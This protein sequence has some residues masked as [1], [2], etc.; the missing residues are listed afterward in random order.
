[1]R[2]ILA[3]LCLCVSIGQAG[4]TV[5][6]YNISAHVDMGSIVEVPIPEYDMRM[7]NQAPRPVNQYLI[8]TAA[9]SYFGQTLAAYLGPPEPISSQT[10]IP[11]AVYTVMGVPNGG[12]YYSDAYAE[13]PEPGTIATLAGGALALWAGHRLKKRR[14]KRSA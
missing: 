1:M 12:G 10:Q 6:E 7:T 9:R 5:A 13:N 2:N 3:G 8:D 14:V 4:N 11:G